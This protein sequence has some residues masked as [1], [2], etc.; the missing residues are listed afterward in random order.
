MKVDVDSKERIKVALLFLLQ[1]YKVIMGS[2]LVVFVP[3]KCDNHVCTV[4][5][6]VYNS[7]PL[8]RAA[9]VTNF[10]TIWFF[11]ITYAIEL[12]RENFCVR[13]FDIN[14]D[15]GDNNL[16]IILKDKPELK[17]ALHS[18]NR[19][20]YR[21]SIITFMVFLIN[22]VISDIVLY[23]D[24]VFWRIGLAPYF[25]YIVLILMKLYNCY[26]ISSDSIKN[27]K[28]LSSYMTE[29][30]SFNVIDVDM[31]SD[32]DIENYGEEKSDTGIGPLPIPVTVMNGN[33]L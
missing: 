15:M 21:S 29:F 2:M 11:V 10:I 30:S 17:N 14:H 25:S 27:D 33:I 9:L 19:I 32:K 24:E 23:N 18:H 8:N 20:Y 16:A 7:N 28:A 1:S 31:L 22:F 26:Y 3:R 5:E 4:R 12:R 13:N 6:N